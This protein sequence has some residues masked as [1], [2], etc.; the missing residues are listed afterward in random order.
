VHE[1]KTLPNLAVGKHHLQIVLPDYNTEEMEVEVKGGQ[2][3]SQGI[4]ALQP[5]AQPQPS[6]TPNAVQAMPPNEPVQKENEQKVAV[7]KKQPRNKK[8]VAA[9]IEKPAQSVIRQTAAAPPPPK[10]VSKP[11]ATPQQKPKRS[12]RP[13][14]GTAPGG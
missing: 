14:D 3:T 1:R 2:M 13:F 9:R 8:P 12:Q 4:I 7:A 10:T 5:I 11:T 6:P